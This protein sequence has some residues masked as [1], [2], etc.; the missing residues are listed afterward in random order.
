MKKIPGW[1]GDDIS[2]FEQTRVLNP[3]PLPGAVDEIKR[4]LALQLPA[5]ANT[6]IEDSWAGMIDVTPDIVPVMD[7][8]GG[9]PGYY[10]AA[11]FCG[12]GFGIGPGAGRVM[13]DMILG[14]PVGHDVSRFRFG[15]FKDGGK[16]ELG[17]AL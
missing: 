16:L 14:N 4:Q 12:H 5:L 13:A 7:S 6:P 11:G 3:E 8:V 15:R 9:L 17:P 1:G 2:P 10:I